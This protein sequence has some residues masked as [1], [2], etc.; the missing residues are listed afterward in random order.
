MPLAVQA[1]DFGK[2]E[3]CIALSEAEHRPMMEQLFPQH[4]AR[5]R[6]WRIEDLAL[7]PPESAIA[8]IETE[9][10]KLL[11]ELCQPTSSPRITF[12]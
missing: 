2:Y 5:V 10:C 12:R 6:F 8:K 1:T 7:E 11:G 3:R 9:V 4:L